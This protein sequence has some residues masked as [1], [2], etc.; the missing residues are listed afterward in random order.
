[1]VSE[2]TIAGP[3]PLRPALYGGGTRRARHA[4]PALEKAT[5]SCLP[6]TSLAMRIAASLDSAP[7]ESSHDPVE[8]GRQRGQA[9]RQVDD[10]PR[11]HSAEQMRD[12]FPS[13]AGRF[14]RSRREWPTNATH[15]SRCEIEDGPIVRIRKRRSP[16][17]LDDRRVE[18]SAI[19]IRCLLAAAR[20]RDPDCSTL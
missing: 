14:R 19:G 13:V 8:A 15:L 7:V 1:M 2:P 6:V 11:Q 16:G 10:R 4:V 12:P 20:R 5:I 3:Y 9:L 18:A 17:P